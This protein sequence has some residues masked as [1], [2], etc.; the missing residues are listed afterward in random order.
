MLTAAVSRLKAS[1]SELLARV[2]AG[3]ELI[4][5]ERGRPVAKIM[6]LRRDPAGLPADLLELER[7]GLVRI[8]SG[9][10]PR[11]FWALPRPKDR[12]GAAQRA[13]LEE[14]TIGR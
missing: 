13:L 2:K 8:G 14:R 1:L 11:G 10:L 9:R 4:V 5:T 3:E 12:A 7:A 6:P